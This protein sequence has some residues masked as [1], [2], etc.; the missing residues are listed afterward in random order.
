MRTVAKHPQTAW[1]RLDDTWSDDR[2]WSA[3]LAADRLRAAQNQ[4]LTQ[5]E[6]TSEIVRRAGESEAHAVALTG[7][8][9]RNCRTDIS[10]LDYHVVGPRF[11]TSDLAGD[12]D[13]HFV[14]A[15][16]FWVRLHAGDDFVQ[17]TLRF[18]CIL[19][20]DGIFRAGLRAVGTELIWPDAGAKFRRLTE[21]QRLAEQL[22]KMADRDA[23]QDQ[24]RATLTSL[25]RALLLDNGIF[26][27]A[28]E[29]LPGQLRSIG[30]G[31]VAGAL[32]VAIH[33]QPSLSDIRAGL[34]LLDDADQVQVGKRR[35]STPT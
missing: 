8:T 20:D 21:M 19:V 7:S 14:D 26:P 15:T 24:L 6:I 28:R 12:V 27:L 4:T 33:G 31:L 35:A 3:K 34:C 29:E 30:H 10:D 11:K 17:W 2:V 16:G 23:A 1:Q 32:T 13:V 5:R 18:G 25:A 22:V 9:A